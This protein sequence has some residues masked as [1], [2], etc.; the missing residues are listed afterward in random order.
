[1]ISL[2]KGRF[3]RSI[4][5]GLVLGILGLAIG[6]S[7]AGLFLEE[8]Y[9]LEMLFDLRGVRNP[10]PDAI[11][12]S[13]DRESARPLGLGDDFR[14]WPRSVYARIIDRL[15]NLGAAAIVLDVVFEDARNPAE[16]RLLVDAVR[17]AGNVVLCCYLKSERMPVV[18][19]E[20][21][22][23]A[24]LQ[25]TELRLP[26]HPL[27]GAA[28]GV[29]PF[30]LPKV[31]ARV[32]QYWTFK[33]GAGDTPTLP[34]AALQ[35]YSA[36]VHGHFSSLMDKAIALR[37][38][39]PSL[40]SQGGDAPQGLH[41]FISDMRGMFEKE[42]LLGVA[43]REELERATIARANPETYRKIGALISM[44]QA[45]NSIYLNFYGP[46]RTIPTIPCHELLAPADGA[47]SAKK[48]P[49]VRGKAVFVGHAPGVQSEQKE[50]FLTVF[51]LPDGLDL[52]GVEIAATAFLN[53]LDDI[54]LKPLGVLPHLLIL[55]FWGL[56]MGATACLFRARFSTLI[57][58]TATLAYLG[59]AVWEFT[60]HALWY[61]LVVTLIVQTP[62]AFVGSIAMGYFSASRERQNIQKALEI[63]VPTDVAE[64]LA[65]N[66]AGFM[67]SQEVVYGICLWTDAEQYT[68][69]SQ[70]KDPRFVTEFMNSYFRLIF[71]PVRR[72]G[73]IISN[74][75]GDSVLAIWGAPAAN[76]DLRRKA[77]AAALEISAAV[78][79]A[80]V[81]SPHP[82]PRTRTS[83]H[84][85]SIAIGH[86]GAMDHYE[87][88]PM[89]DIVNTTTRIDGINRLLGTSIL[90]SAEAILELDG[91]LTREVGTFLVMGKSTPLQLH[92]LIGP[93]ETAEERQID[94]CAHFAEGLTAYRRLS[95]D[96][97]M[98]CLQRAQQSFGQ[99]SV[100][101]FY[102]ERC[103]Y[104]KAH[105]PEA[106]W[107]GTIKMA[108]K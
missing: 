68:A 49:A 104:H 65:K 33:I 107:D 24:S 26:M 15:H 101:A 32:S 1:M 71:T 99:D 94:G 108:T 87:Y 102:I 70:D 85:G 82:V 57:L 80:R 35:A 45:P 8:R 53:L 63:Y 51:S 3:I 42:P 73:G 37:T 36:D 60:Q 40:R 74:V 54:P 47:G 11:I 86:V 90:A 20:G 75:M 27:A 81:T 58:A 9:G 7:P 13:I 6:L 105:P 77:C 17:R 38:L 92:E 100:S 2:G 10:S 50:G 43:M 103:L 5:V 16:D 44:Y 28:A 23:G 30:P 61:P 89:G 83:L 19:R 18:K 46:P 96:E 25:I 34:V 41:G 67:E 64:K 12:V 66:M 106:P 88:R 79:Q 22:P 48:D 29:A 84:A 21:E 52:A 4:I 93:F 39:P 97:A 31:P 69:F 62:L 95:W 78:E 55:F 72:H 98:A 76:R 56:T 91:L 14:R 59:A